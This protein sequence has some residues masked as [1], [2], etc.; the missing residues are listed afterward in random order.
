MNS[1]RSSSDAGEEG[2]MSPESLLPENGFGGLANR[3]LA[4]KPI[5]AAVNGYALGRTHY[6]MTFYSIAYHLC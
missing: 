4:R 1:E 6:F 5:I 2:G 3:R